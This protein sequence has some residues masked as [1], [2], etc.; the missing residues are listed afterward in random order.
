MNRKFPILFVAIAQFA[1]TAFAEATILAG[2]DL[3][4]IDAKVKELVASMTLDEKM[5]FLHGDKE[6][7]RYDGPP[8][9]PRLGIFCGRAKR[10]GD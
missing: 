8:A 9:I 1:S 6:R 4:A 7:M 10:L 3:V 5:L 2:E